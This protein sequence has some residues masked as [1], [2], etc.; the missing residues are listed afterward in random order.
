MSARRKLNTYKS[1]S[2]SV[3]NK[4]FKTLQCSPAIDNKNDITCYSN[5][6]LETM[7]TMWN[8]K[9]STDIIN[10]TDP[11]KIWKALREKFANVCDS[12]KCWMRQNF[13]KGKLGNDV[14]Q[15][16]FAPDAPKSWSVNPT[17]WLSSSDISN[18]MSHFEKYYLQFSFIGPS[19]IDFDTSTVGDKCVWPELCNF[20]LTNMLAKRK[21]K[22]G[23]IFNTDVHT[24]SG[25]HWVSM[26]ID[27]RAKPHPYIFYFDSTGEPAVVE[28][29]VF[30]ERIIKQAADIGLTIRF[31]ENTK[32]HQKSDSEC[33]MYSLY[34]IIELL[35]GK[36]DYSYFL[37]NRVPD[38]SMM[39]FRNI[40]FNKHA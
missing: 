12:E 24:G 36:K 3:K 26:F 35:T 7:K 13:V 19:P 1:S 39:E 17:E 2:R 16:T 40:Y 10:E 22:V 9:H 37:N 38:K 5:S 30:A 28:I 33:G 34:L 15:Y 6:T 21:T 4:K 8:T 18:V 14:S 25:E 32:E 23:I 11:I 31:Y 27:L 20:N 29:N